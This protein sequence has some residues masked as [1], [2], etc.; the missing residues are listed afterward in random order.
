MNESDSNSFPLE[1]HKNKRVIIKTLPVIF[2]SKMR[3]SKENNFESH[4]LLRE[5]ALNCKEFFNH[6]AI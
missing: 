5:Q 6:D 3:A 4:Y 2:K 1:A